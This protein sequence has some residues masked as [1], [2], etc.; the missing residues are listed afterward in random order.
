MTE[1][2]LSAK[3]KDH[4]SSHPEKIMGYIYTSLAYLLWGFLALYWNALDTVSSMEILAHR[5]LWGFIFVVIIMIYKPK[6]RRAFFTLLKEFK[7]NF[8]QFFYIFVA[9]LAI[10]A[11][12]LIY[13]WAVNFGHII[14]ASLGLY[15][16]PIVSMILGALILKDNVR[17]GVLAAMI[18]AFLGVLAITY[19]YGKIPW[20]AFSSAI[21]S[22]IY[23]LA[24]KY[25]KT[26]ALVGMCIET[27]MVTPF[28]LLFL[29]FLQ[30]NHKMYFGLDIHLSLLLM[31]A[32][33]LTV[34]P[35][36]W[37][38]EGSKRISLTTIGFF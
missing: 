31:G 7:V 24:K 20:I 23:G 16:T 17:I 33:I 36:L 30:R 15:I 29:G 5:I 2:N 26:D 1:W 14:E 27:M 9:S 34:L 10:S 37:F 28:A 19:D 12:W 25:I 35:L 11:N 32:G 3:E 22:G 38:T 18:L 21:T 4:I 8:K 13:I 6:K